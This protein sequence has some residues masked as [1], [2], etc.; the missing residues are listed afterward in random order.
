MT[1]FIII[2]TLDMTFFKKNERS[3]M[4][5]EVKKMLTF[6]VGGSTEQFLV[7]L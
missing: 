2:Y 5:L 4:I 6:L 7:Y 3:N 1:S